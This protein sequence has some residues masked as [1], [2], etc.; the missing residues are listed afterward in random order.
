MSGKGP[1]KFPPPSRD[2]RT[3]VQTLRAEYLAH[4]LRNHSSP[5]RAYVPTPA[6]DAASQAVFEETQR[7]IDKLYEHYGVDANDPKPRIRSCIV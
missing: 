1:P 2:L 3:A 7:R 4:A 5:E 6:H